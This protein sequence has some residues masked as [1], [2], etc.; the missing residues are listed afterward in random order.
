MNR[1]LLII[2]LI[3]IGILAIFILNS[4]KKTTYANALN[5]QNNYSVDSLYER[6]TILQLFIKTIKASNSVIKCDVGEGGQLINFFVYDL[7]DT[8]NYQ[9]ATIINDTFSKR[10]YFKEGHVYHFATSFF[11]ESFS[12]IAYLENGQ[13]NIFESVNCK[14]SR[15]NVDSVI[16]FLKPKL[17]E[18]NRLIVFERLKRIR[19]F[20]K[21]FS[22]D[23]YSLK[24]KCDCDPCN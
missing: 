20:G 8:L 5:E 1:S 14:E 9:D 3:V 16:N 6:D 13:V 4:A 21:Y 7:D 22:H 15:Y 24:L 19:K 12:N 23:N 18:Q 11:A 17:Q 10:V 2:C